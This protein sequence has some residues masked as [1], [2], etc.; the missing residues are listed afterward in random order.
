MAQTVVK[1]SRC[2]LTTKLAKSYTLN[3]SNFVYVSHTSIK[4]FY[5]GEEEHL[6]NPS[7]LPFFYKTEF[8]AVQDSELEAPGWLRH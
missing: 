5:K 3:L 7:Q 6:L 2:P 1:V 8:S 4:W